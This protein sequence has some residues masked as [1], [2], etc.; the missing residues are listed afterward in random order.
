MMA[1]SNFYTIVLLLGSLA[2]LTLAADKP[3]LII[4]LFRHGARGPLG[5]QDDSWP[6]SE[7]GVLTP[8]GMRQQYILGKVLS[9]RYPQTFNDPYNY[10]QIYMISDVTPRCI[11]SAVTQLYGMYLG[12]GPSLNA[13]YPRSLAVPPYQDARVQSIANSLTNSEAIP[14]NNIPEIV[15]I[16][17]TSNAMIFQG[18]TGFYCPN[19]VD[20]MQQ[21]EDNAGAKRGF[22]VFGTTLDNLN[23][24][25]P[26]DQ[27]VNTTSDM[28]SYGDTMMVD[29]YD[30]RTLPHG[31]TDP[32]LIANLTHAFEYFAFHSWSGQEQQTQLG[33]YNLV[34]AFLD[35]IQAFRLGKNGYK[36]VLYSGHDDNIYA[37]LGAFGVVTE[38][39][40]VDNFNSYLQNGTKVH[41]ACY[42]PFF[43][44]NIIIEF[45]NSTD[46]PY[47]KVLYNNIAL[48]LCNGNYACPLEDFFIFAKNATGNNTS[49][50]YKK[51][52]G[53]KPPVSESKPVGRSALNQASPHGGV[54]VNTSTIAL[55]AMTILCVVLGVKVTK[56]N[57]KYKNLLNK[58]ECEK[59]LYERLTEV[60]V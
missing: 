54:Q 28:V 17:D 3:D 56:D 12:T 44:S 33:A 11:Q 20:W 49:E 29:I 14:Y 8:V 32:A 9:E 15:N 60:R 39:C 31:V 6:L 57:K 38:D 19:Y 59:M 37:V 4:E 21:N 2:L 45:Y 51:N 34:Q 36:A 18:D 5:P 42:F 55:V 10:S 25:L 48:P 46:A 1:K 40:L 41:P 22:E 27:R 26:A 53:V 50:S 16:V 58:V 23:K 13:S 7:W 35:Q 43:A 47:V 52:C 30:N 24:L